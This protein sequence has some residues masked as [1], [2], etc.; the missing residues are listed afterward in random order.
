M[1]EIPQSQ[2][3]ARV[4]CITLYRALILYQL[5]FPS[6]FHSCVFIFPYLYSLTIPQRWYYPPSATPLFSWQIDSSSPYRARYLL[7]LL[8]LWRLFLLGR[9]AFSAY[10]LLVPPHSTHSFTYCILHSDSS[11]RQR[12][13]V[14]CNFGHIKYIRFNMQLRKEH[15]HK[16]TRIQ[17][18][19]KTTERIPVC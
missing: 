13:F 17:T 10:Y 1:D 4:V 5:S 8:L 3:I 15:H 18:I 11:S 16:T 6:S 9:N 19:C 12:P 2:L 7:F 14:H